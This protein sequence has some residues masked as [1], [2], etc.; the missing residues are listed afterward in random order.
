[1][2]NL[3]KLRGKKGISSTEFSRKLGITHPAL[4][5]NEGKK[6]SVKNALKSSE[7]LGENVFLLLW[8]DVLLL[9]PKTEEDKQILIKMISEL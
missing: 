2:N 7:I 8:D 6:L 1:M 5:Y 3:A 4:C 9:K